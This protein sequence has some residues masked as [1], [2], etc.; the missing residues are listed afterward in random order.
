MCT[1]DDGILKMNLNSIDIKTSCIQ[2]IHEHFNEIIPNAHFNPE[3][4]NVFSL[5]LIF[6]LCT[7]GFSQMLDEN[8]INTDY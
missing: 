1:I 6:I 2:I 3:L 5:I 7:V 8:Q 4:F